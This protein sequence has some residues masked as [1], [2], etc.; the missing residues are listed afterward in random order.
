MRPSS[1]PQ[2]VDLSAN[3]PEPIMMSIWRIRN[4]IGLL[5]F[6]VA[7]CSNGADPG[8]IDQLIGIALH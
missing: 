1:K 7:A 6:T 2:V 5:G 4:V 3:D 8:S